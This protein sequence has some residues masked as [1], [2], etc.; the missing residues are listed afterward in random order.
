MTTKSTIHV[1][2]P[3]S[4]GGVTAVSVAAMPFEIKSFDPREETRPRVT[5]VKA[6]PRRRFGPRAAMVARA[7]RALA[8][9]E[10]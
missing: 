9:Q 3:G 6:P 2:D 8:K 5:L 10:E 4:T 7:I 1:R